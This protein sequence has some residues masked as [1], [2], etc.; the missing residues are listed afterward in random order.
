MDGSDEGDIAGLATAPR[1]RFKTPNIFLS[2]LSSEESEEI[3]DA[4]LKSVGLANLICRLEVR[5]ENSSE[6]EED[7]RRI[8]KEEKLQSLL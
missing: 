2:G 3:S 8:L 6:I 5:E 1:K 7:P 4:F